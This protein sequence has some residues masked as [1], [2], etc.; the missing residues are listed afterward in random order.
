[1]ARNPE[2]KGYVS[3]ADCMEVWR[4]FEFGFNVELQLRCEVKCPPG[5]QYNKMYYELVAFDKDHN[6]VPLLNRVLG[7]YPAA[8]YSTVPGMLLGM[9]YVMEVQLGNVRV[10]TEPIFKPPQVRASTLK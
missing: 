6:Q 2:T 4:W 8:T 5:E 1:M 9:L 7:S 3:W 10:W